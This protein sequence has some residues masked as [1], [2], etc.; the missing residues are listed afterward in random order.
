MPVSVTEGPPRP[1]CTFSLS[2]NLRA[3]DW[4][5]ETTPFDRHLRIGDWSPATLAVCQFNILKQ[6]AQISVN[7]HYVESYCFL[8]YKSNSLPRMTDLGLF[9]LFAFLQFNQCSFLGNML[10]GAR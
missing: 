9:L 1:F 8:F 5:P 3:P 7:S 4:C 10:R 6:T 2:G